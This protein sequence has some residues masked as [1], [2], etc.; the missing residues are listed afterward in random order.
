MTHHPVKARQVVDNNTC[1]PKIS[2]NI[3]IDV[4]T[5]ILRNIRNGKAVIDIEIAFY[6]LGHRSELKSGAPG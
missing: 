2:Y 4:I 1:G 3:Y 5:F 6:S